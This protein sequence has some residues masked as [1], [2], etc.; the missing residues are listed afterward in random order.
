MKNC[1]SLLSLVVKKVWEIFNLYLTFHQI[2]YFIL[3][4][5]LRYDESGRSFVYKANG[6]IFHPVHTQRLDEV[7]AGMSQCGAG[8]PRKDSVRY[9]EWKV[10]LTCL[11]YIDIVQNILL[12]SACARFRFGSILFVQDC[13]PIH[14]H[15]AVAEFFEDHPKFELLLWLRKGADLK[16][17]EGNGSRTGCTIF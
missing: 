10:R 9:T 15:H 5:N 14:T 13:S 7:I 16:C 6:T 11:T 4:L 12:P 2:I 8:F 3:Y 1:G 17:L